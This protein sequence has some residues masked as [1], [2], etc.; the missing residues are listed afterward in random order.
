MLTVDPR[1]YEGRLD[2]ALAAL[3]PESLPIVRCRAWPARWTRAAGIGDLG[4]RSL[5]GLYRSCATLLRD[6]AFDVLFITTYPTYPALLGPMLKRRFGIPFVVDLQDPWVGAWGATVGGGRGGGPDVKSRLA[7]AL[8]A[9]LERTVLP[10]ADGITAVSAA[11]YDE[12]LARVPAARASVRCAIPL[13]GEE[14]DFDAVRRDPRA[15]T[16][17]DPRDGNLH[18]C[19]VGTLLPLGIAPAT[20]LL[21]AFAKLRH[22]REELYRRVRLHF[23]GTSNQTGGGDKRVEPIALAMGVADIVS[24]HPARVDYSEAIR[25]QACAGAIL[26]LGSVERHYTPSKVFPALLARRPILAAFHE[27][28]DVV[29]LVRRAVQWPSLRVVTYAD[30]LS[31]QALADDLYAQVVALLE[32]PAYDIRDT[33]PERFAEFSAA[34]MAGRLAAV[35]DA[36]HQKRRRAA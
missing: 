19:Y 16:F 33:S 13:G 32:H 15:T 5:A 8:G 26:L 30:R 14:R 20:A 36:V 12:A 29:D 7:R 9:W 4:L 2:P 18:L 23:I 28:S 34:T 25:I 24:E 21:A 3:V 11:T 27:R 10:S 35:F 22:T 17:F 6:D 1:D 31:P